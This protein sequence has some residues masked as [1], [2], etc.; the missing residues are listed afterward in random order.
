MVNYSY[1]YITHN[2]QMVFDI[3]GGGNLV[4]RYSVPQVPSCF[5]DI[6][7]TELKNALYIRE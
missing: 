7:V 6:G 2:N 4:L 5:R 1:K 3:T